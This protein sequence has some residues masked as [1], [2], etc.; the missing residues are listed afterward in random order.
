MNDGPP[1]QIQQF[2][3]DPSEF[4]PLDDLPAERALKPL[5][6]PVW[7]KNKAHFN[8]HYLRYFVLIA[9]HGTYIDGFAGPQQGKMCNTWSARLVL[10]SEPRWI[11]HFHLCDKQASQ[12]DLLKHLKAQQP[13]GEYERNIEI[14]LGDFNSKVDEILECGDITDKEATF[15]LLDQR[16][17]E[18]K[19]ATVEKLA[20]FKTSGHKIELFYFLANAWFERAFDAQKDRDVIAAW[21][22]RDDLTELR[23]M[24]REERSAVMVRR[25][26]RQFGYHSV[27][28]WPIYGQEN[29]GGVVMYYMVHAADHPESRIQM[30]RA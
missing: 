17:F 20:K 1:L 16:T 2:L 7:T 24:S 4:R 10:E 13:P 27:T 18:C 30:E 19:W 11:R 28:A 5:S 26:K 25:F 12:V 6:A 15:C 14:Y 22:G 23:A 29:G 3:F 21:W 9:K 8:M